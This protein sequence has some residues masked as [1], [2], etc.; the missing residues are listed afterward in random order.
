MFEVYDLPDLNITCE[1]RAVSTVPTQALTMLNNEFVLLEATDFAKRVA[2][3]AGS[4]ARAQVRMLYH[5]AFSREPTANEMTSSLEFLKKQPGGSG[6]TDL[7][8]VALNLNEFVYI[9]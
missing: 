8:H 3:E 4:D 7:A 1:R 2:R 5:I 9:E 6:L